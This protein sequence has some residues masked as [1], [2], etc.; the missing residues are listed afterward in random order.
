MKYLNRVFIFCF[1]LKILH[2]ASPYQSNDIPFPQSMWASYNHSL[3]YSTASQSVA[4]QPCYFSST[5]SKGETIL[6]DNF[7]SHLNFSNLLNELK[8]SSFL[9]NPNYLLNSNNLMKHLRSIEDDDLSFSISYIIS[10]INE[11]TVGYHTT[12]KESLL[13]ALGLELLEKEKKN[14]ALLCGDS[15]LTSYNKGIMLLYSLK[16]NFHTKEDKELFIQ[17]KIDDYG[18]FSTILTK[19]ERK[20]NMLNLNG[21]LEIKYIQIGGNVEVFK[22]KTNPNGEKCEFTK[23]SNCKDTVN[24]LQ[25]YFAND[26][27]PQYENFPFSHDIISVNTFTPV[28]DVL[29]LPS[30]DLDAKIKNSQDYIVDFSKRYTYYLMYLQTVPYYPVYSEVL[31][32]YYK[33]VEDLLKSFFSTNPILCF[34][35]ANQTCVDIYDNFYNTTKET[36]IE[37]NII[38]TLDTMKTYSIYPAVF[39]DDVCLKGKMKWDRPYNLNMYM[40]PNGKGKGIAIFSSDFKF[41]NIKVDDVNEDFSL[42]LSDGPFNFNIQVHNKKNKNMAIVSCIEKTK[43]LS[44]SFNVAREDKENPFYFE[45]YV[46]KK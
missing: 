37:T 14:F 12:S 1:V 15:L 3:A 2:C 42:D 41:G 40:F 7:Y 33:D 23:L 6:R 38:T 25:N 28:S 11:Y 43:K 36:N 34:E 29:A 35:Y 5:I 24:L 18:E 46:P 9:S 4:K 32:K 10:K 45:K 8:L 27:L 30:F 17:D 20:F 22:N 44:K 31:N 13:T 19:L 39:K 16:L 26:F 21:L